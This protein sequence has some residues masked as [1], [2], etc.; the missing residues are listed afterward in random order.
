[1][2]TSPP[3]AVA[4]ATDVARQAG[5]TM[6]CDPG[7]GAFLAVLAAAVPSGGRILELGT[8]SG[9]GTA[10]IL[11]G[12]GA[13][14]DVEVVTVDLDPAAADRV[15]RLSWP[16]WVRVVIGDAVEVTSR[17]GTFDL[18]FADAQGGKWTGLD[19]TIAALRPG[20]HLLVD[21]MVPPSF[22]DRLHE[23]KTAE[24][25]ATLLGH[26]DLIGVPIEW[27]SGLILCTRRPEK[28]QRR[29][30]GSGQIVST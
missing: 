22:A 1:M 26:P 20:G 5:F 14:T 9:V 12:V 6:S 25:R 29:R 24:V 2:S 23:E 17:E 10:W 11:H 13:R 7:T 18:I 30:S 28:R 16:L 21:D 15:G 4:R 3:D 19:V 27:A 8:G